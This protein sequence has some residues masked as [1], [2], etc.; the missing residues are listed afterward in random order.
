MVVSAPIVYLTVCVSGV[1]NKANK[2]GRSAIYVV[3]QP[4][5]PQ[6]HICAQSSSSW[7]QKNNTSVAY[8]L[9]ERPYKTLK[10]KYLEIFYV[11]MPP[12]DFVWDPL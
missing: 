6:Q 12:C 1:M 9:I 11:L 4:P 2:C 3:S 8:V 7:K 5:S 10:R